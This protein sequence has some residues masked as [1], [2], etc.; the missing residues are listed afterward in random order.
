MKINLIV[1]VLLSFLTIPTLTAGTKSNKASSTKVIEKNITEENP[2]V[3]T[4]PMAGETV[5][6]QVIS[7]GG[8]NGSSTSY[9][10]QGTVG[11]TAVGSGVSISYGIGHGYWQIFSDGSG[12]CCLGVRGDVNCSGSEPDISD[13]TRL[14]DYLY[15]SHSPLCWCRGSRCQCQWGRAGHFGYYPAY[16]FPLSFSCPLGRLP[17]IQISF[18]KKPPL[19][20]KGGFFVNFSIVLRAGWKRGMR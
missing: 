15:L 10:L 6:W 8:A 16:R 3:I 2:V 1:I 14:I 5:T 12:G 7:G 18:I 11:Q 20:I 19:I 17:V 4:Q 9:Q 13:I